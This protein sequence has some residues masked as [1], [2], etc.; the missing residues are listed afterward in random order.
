MRFNIFEPYIG[1]STSNLHDIVEILKKYYFLPVGDWP[2]CVV[3][4]RTFT[5][6]NKLFL[7][8]AKL[9]TV[10][11]NKH[12]ISLIIKDKSHLKRYYLVFQELKF[13]WSIKTL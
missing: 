3:E 5:R 12:T 4:I 11:G 6:N 8:D 9:R 10:E 1:F 13:K 7:E 2:K